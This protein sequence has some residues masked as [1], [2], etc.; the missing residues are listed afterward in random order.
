V[1]PEQPMAEFVD[2]TRT[3]SAIPTF[4]P[5]CAAAKQ[6]CPMP[7]PPRYRGSARSPSRIR[8]APVIHGDWERRPVEVGGQVESHALDQLKNQLT[9]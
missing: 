2:D 1:I 3:S 9:W 5:A 4:C 6:K 8:P 7:L